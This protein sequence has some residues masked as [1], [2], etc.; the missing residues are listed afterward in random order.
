MPR[1]ALERAASLG[2]VAR[3]PALSA[4]DLPF[5]PHRAGR[6]A[7]CRER[8][9]DIAWGN[10]ADR[11]QCQRAE[12]SGGAALPVRSPRAYQTLRVRPAAWILDRWRPGRDFHHR[13]TCAAGQEQR[14]TRVTAWNKAGSVNAGRAGPLASPLRAT[15]AMIEVWH[16]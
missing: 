8:R 10:T 9:A 3:C 11:A 1:P 4:H 15:E 13:L 12:V 6:S 2:G 16:A 14:R 5:E 7:G